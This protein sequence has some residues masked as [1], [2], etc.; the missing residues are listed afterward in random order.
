MT[1]HKF[2]EGMMKTVVWDLPPNPQEWR[3][4]SP[5]VKGV[6]SGARG[7]ELKS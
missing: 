4:L 2:S 1:A 7:P 5:V 6:G 3:A